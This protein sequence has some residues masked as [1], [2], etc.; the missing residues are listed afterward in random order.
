IRAVTPLRNGG[1]IV[2]LDSEELATW[3]REPTGRA[4][5]EEQFESTVSFR[6]RTFALVLEYLPIRLQLDD[7]SLL[8]RVEIEN[9]LPADSLSTIRWIKPVARRSAEQRKA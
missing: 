9:N 6:S 2:E 3:L 8:R 1:I 7:A 5:L 4:L